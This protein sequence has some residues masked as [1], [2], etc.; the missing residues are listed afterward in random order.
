MLEVPRLIKLYIL[1]SSFKF[2]N[3]ISN[4][5]EAGKLYSILHYITGWQWCVNNTLELVPAFRF[6]HML[7]LWGTGHDLIYKAVSKRGL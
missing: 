2:T 5:N 6:N 3:E 1:A 4:E 7:T